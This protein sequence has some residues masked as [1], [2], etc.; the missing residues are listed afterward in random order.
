MCALHN[1]VLNDLKDNEFTAGY[2]RRVVLT[3]V[4]LLFLMPSVA[5]NYSSNQSLQNG[6]VWI[7][8]ENSWIEIIDENN[9][10][11]VN[12]SNYLGDIES[13]NY[14]V[15]SPNISDCQT[16]LPISQ[17]FPNDRPIPG[18]SFESIDVVTCPQTGVSIACE[19]VLLAGDLSNDTS[20]IFAIMY[21]QP[22]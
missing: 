16:I 9:N 10:T 1:L 11:I 19:G 22:I 18:A 5:A 12:S 20:D 2:M 17:D 14:T 7:D 3:L 21:L 8:C 6:K 4:C 15:N 13:G